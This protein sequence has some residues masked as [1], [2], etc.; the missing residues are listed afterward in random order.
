MLIYHPCNRAYAFIHSGARRMPHSLLVLARARRRR[1]RRRRR[2]KLVFE[3]AKRKVNCKVRR[4]ER[5]F[6]GILQ[7]HIILSLE[8]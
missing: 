5:D 3:T 1:R 8:F 6:H 2:L 7:V 4:H